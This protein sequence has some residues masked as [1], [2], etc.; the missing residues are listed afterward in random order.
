MKIIKTTFS[1]SSLII[2]AEANGKRNEFE[3]GNF[4]FTSKLNSANKQRALRE[5]LE[6]NALEISKRMNV[7]LGEAAQAVARYLHP[8]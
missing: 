4:D 2:A 5:I 1:S 6:G 7:T 8:M 3:I